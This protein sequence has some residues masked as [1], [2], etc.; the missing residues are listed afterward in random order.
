[1]QPFAISSPKT[2]ARAKTP[3]DARGSMQ[4]MRNIQPTFRETKE[5]KFYFV[6]DDNHVMQKKAAAQRLKEILI[7]KKIE[8][9]IGITYL[10]RVVF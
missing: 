6:N 5:S 1:M 8:D 7:T 4:K 2:K 10:H 9:S 3:L